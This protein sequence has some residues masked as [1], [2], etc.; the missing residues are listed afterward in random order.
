[1]Q[2]NLMGALR[3][4]PPGPKW[5]PA[6]ATMLQA[7][8]VKKYRP[9]R[10]SAGQLGPPSS[11][12][13]CNLHPA[14]PARAMWVMLC[15]CPAWCVCRSSQGHD[16]T[17]SHGSTEKQRQRGWLQLPGESFFFFPYSDMANPRS[18]SETS[19]GPARC[20]SC[21]P[22]KPQGVETPWWPTPSP[23]P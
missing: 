1:M 4:V 19:V 10:L 13:A 14:G 23:C 11:L 18:G 9:C 15:C 8:R 2:T 12:A 16:E 20:L 5:L 7:L 17:L 6:R 3:I 21:T 22:R